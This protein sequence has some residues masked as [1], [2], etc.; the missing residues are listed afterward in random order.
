MAADFVIMRT[1]VLALV[2]VGSWASIA[3][4]QGE[5]DVTALQMRACTLI[6]DEVA[7][8]RCYDHAMSRPGSESPLV[9]V[10]QV[11]STASGAPLVTIPPSS[12]AVPSQPPPAARPQPSATANSA[13]S[14]VTIPQPSVATTAQSA[15][16]PQ[17][18]TASVPASPPATTPITPKSGTFFDKIIGTIS[19]STPTVEESWQVKADKLQ[20]EQASQLL[21]TLTS[22]DGNSTLVLKCNT[23]STEAYVTTS[24]FLGWESLRVLYRVNGNPVTERRWAASAKGNEA[25]SDNAIDF[26]NTLTDN[27]TLMVT[28]FDYNG[29]KHDLT[30]NL[31]S[32]SGLRSRIASV[33]RRPTVSSTAVR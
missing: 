26:I 25:V 10:P 33:C 30:F 31:G 32:V 22:T 28:V 9:T 8:V 17:S 1:I 7:R 29:T 16:V 11:G 27:G 6:A 23:N 13:A 20:L 14:S 4:A 15:T 3:D 5:P 18:A 21:G 24:S 12:I 2:A 19:P